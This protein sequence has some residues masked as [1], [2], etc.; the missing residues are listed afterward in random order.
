VI[1][2]ADEKR[3][4]GPADGMSDVEYR[5]QKLERKA[6]VFDDLAEQNPAVATEATEA[7]LMSRVE[8]MRLRRAAGGGS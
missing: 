1:V 4:R 3:R 8:A 6:Q 5:A 2:V 7:A